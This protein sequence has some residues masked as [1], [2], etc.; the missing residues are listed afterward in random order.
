M[1][2]PVFSVVIV[3]FKRVDFLIKAIESVLKQTL[4]NYE[5]LVF[6]DFP[7]DNAAI[8]KEIARLSDERFRF[9][10]S[11]SSR[12]A[13]HWRNAGIKMA[14]GEY[15]AFLD[16]DD[17]WFPEKLT[18]HYQAHQNHDAFLVYSDYIKTWSESDLPDVYKEN[19]RIGE[20]IKR[21]MA[22]GIFSIS[23][24]SSVSLLNKIDWQVFDESLMSFQDWDAWLNLTI[25]QPNA[26]FHHIKKPLIYYTHHESNK[27][28]KN[29]RRRLN[30]LD[31]VKAKYGEKEIDVSGFFFKEKLN[32]L[33]AELKKSKVSTF[34]S[35][36]RLATIL[37]THPGLFGY[38]YTY[39]RIGRFLFKDEDRL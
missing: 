3:T 13:N 8:E 7:E 15:I 11:Q 12:G 35:I 29:Y 6:N 39:R 31:Q 19:A 34:S 17:H 27:V 16:D 10:P 2:H 25:V 23:T 24:T 22:N 5:C 18:E 38:P 4:T 21:E 9:I 36:S 37:I 14:K 30:A 26:K 1:T 33:L 20:N 28:T 32:L